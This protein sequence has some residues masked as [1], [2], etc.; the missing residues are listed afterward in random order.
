MH[1][2]GLEKAVHFKGRVTSDALLESNFLGAD[3]LVLPSLEERQGKVL[4]EAMARRIPV[5]ASS[6]G[7]IPSIISHGQNGLLFDPSSVEELVDSIKALIFNRELRSRLI[8]KGN[9]FARSNTLEAGV[10][11]LIKIVREHYFSEENVSR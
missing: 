8:E 5:V 3:I 10:E 4:V 1:S 2:F 9:D 7:G 11:K 6:I